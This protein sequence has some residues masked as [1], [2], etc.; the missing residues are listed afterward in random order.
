MQCRAREVVI[1]INMR[2]GNTIRSLN[3]EGGEVP[4]GG[5]VLKPYTYI[6]GWII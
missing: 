1:K 6:L 4:T 2:S 3:N 5:W